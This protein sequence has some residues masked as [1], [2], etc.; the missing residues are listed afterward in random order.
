[1]AA[2]DSAA[3]L[4]VVVPF[5]R[6]SKNGHFLFRS[7]QRKNARSAPATQSRRRHGCERHPPLR[8]PP[9]PHSRHGRAGPPL[10]ARKSGDI[11]VHL[12]PTHAT[13]IAGPPSPHPAPTIGGRRVATSPLYRTA[14]EEG[15]DA[16]EDGHHGNCKRG[17]LGEGTVKGSTRVVVRPAACGR[18]RRGHLPVY[19]PPPARHRVHERSPSPTGTTLCGQRCGALTAPA[20]ARD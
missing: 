3:V 14:L 20:H 12:R 18:G 4:P 9:T 8:L 11:P 17:T 16:T 6:G 13:A 19:A 7:T 5:W 1:M 15:Q 10:E 2:S